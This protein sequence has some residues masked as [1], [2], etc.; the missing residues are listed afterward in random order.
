MF[1]WLVNFPTITMLKSKV[2]GDRHVETETS[3][4]DQIGCSKYLY[5]SIEVI[6]LSSASLA[7]ISHN[8]SLFSIC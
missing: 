4:Y 2:V 8:F 7:G 1:P 3:R 5:S 6:A